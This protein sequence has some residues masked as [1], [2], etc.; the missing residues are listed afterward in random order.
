MPG[1]A[2]DKKASVARPMV[3]RMSTH[4]PAS[5]SISP[6]ILTIRSQRV[7]LDTVLAELYDVPTRR[8]NEAVRRN[9]AR[10]PAEFMFQLTADEWSALRSQFATLDAAPAGRGQHR[11]YLPLVFTEH[12]AIMA[13]SLLNSRRAIEVSIYVVRA[14]VRLRELATSHAELAKRLDELEHKT[15]ALARAHDGFSR[16]THAQLQ[17]VFDALR[18]LMTPPDPPKRPIGFVTPAVKP[19]TPRARSRR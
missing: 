14:F 10:F 13:A 4:L 16:N 8:F 12:G 9:L 6:R 5:E 11:K 7:I 19:P 2:W 15:D 17:Q 1:S 18:Q 3:A